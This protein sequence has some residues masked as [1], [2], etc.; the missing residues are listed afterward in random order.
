VFFMK[1]RLDNCL[2]KVPLIQNQF[3]V[4]Y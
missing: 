1:L 2:T 4:H 3:K